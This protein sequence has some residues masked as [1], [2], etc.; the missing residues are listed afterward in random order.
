MKKYIYVYKIYIYVY[1]NI[2]T[3]CLRNKIFTFLA[4]NNYIEHNIQK[5]FTPNVAGT[6]E[7][8][9]HI[10]TAALPIEL[11]SQQGLVA[12]LIQ[13]KCTKYFRD[14]IF[15]NISKYFVTKYFTKYFF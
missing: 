7:H 9:A 5:G 6:L 13:F 15:Q 3:S 12:S 1:K 8:T 2:H 10:W 4:E 14:K 11:S